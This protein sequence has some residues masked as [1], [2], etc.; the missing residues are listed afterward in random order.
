MH[1]QMVSNTAL[2]QTVEVSNQKW[3]NSEAPSIFVAGQHTSIDQHTMA[4]PSIQ[5][6]DSDIN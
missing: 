3:P 5:S 6:L 1:I 2:T 4:I